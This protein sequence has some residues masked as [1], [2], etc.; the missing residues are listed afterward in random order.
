LNYLKIPATMSVV[1]NSVVIDSP[2]GSNPSRV[3]IPYPPLKEC[4]PIYIK[5]SGLK[6]LVKFF[7]SNLISISA[8]VVALFSY[9]TL[10][11]AT[12]NLVL[13]QVELAAQTRLLCRL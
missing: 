13:K 9:L 1:V 6:G 2:S 4:E 8:R 5:T 10:I 3:Q 11:Q 7:C 12:L